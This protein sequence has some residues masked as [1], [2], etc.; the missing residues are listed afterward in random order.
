M[1]FDSPVYNSSEFFITAIV[2]GS[3]VAV[4]YKRLTGVTPGGIVPIGASLILLI[5]NPLWA[6]FCFALS[7]IGFTAYLLVVTR[8]DKRGG[9]P[10]VYSI[11]VITLLFGLGAAYGLQLQG[12]LDV[13]GM[14]VG[15]LVVPAILANQYRL[16]G[17][18]RVVSGYLTCIL[19]SLLLVVC[20]VYIANSFGAS[21]GL[22]AHFQTQHIPKETRYLEFYPLAA[23]VSLVFGFFVYRNFGLRSGGYIMAPLAAQLITSLNSCLILASGVFVLYFM[24]LFLTRFT[25]IVGLQR[26]L[27]NIVLSSV[28]VWLSIL[29]VQRVLSSQDANSFGS[30]WIMVLVIASYSTDLY[31]YRSKKSYLY[32]AL[33]TAIAFVLIKLLRLAVAV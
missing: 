12:L 27:A 23:I 21:E 13:Q 30:A 9:F 24:Q 7:F 4:Y 31:V 18:K 17:I 32:I 6:V 15:G 16:Y 28:Y 22:F 11:S 1:I 3:S 10:H 5:R 25:F 20:L 33:N 14:T 29:F 26:Y 19:A 2:I 8:L